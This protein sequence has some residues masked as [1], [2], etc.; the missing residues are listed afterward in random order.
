MAPVIRPMARWAVSIIY[1]AGAT[2]GVAADGGVSRQ[3]TRTVVAAPRE[4]IS[5]FS[6]FLVPDTV[7]AQC[8][9]HHQA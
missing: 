4:A 8:P 2:V 7:C 9:W 6:M 3:R 5:V 1:C